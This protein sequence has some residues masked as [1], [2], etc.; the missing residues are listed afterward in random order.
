MNLPDRLEKKDYQEKID[1]LIELTE[2]LKESLIDSK[3]LLEELDGSIDQGVREVMKKISPWQGRNFNEWNGKEAEL[4]KIIVL[5]RSLKYILKRRTKISEE[6]L[7][8]LK[9]DKLKNR[10]K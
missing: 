6:D 9:E 4:K 8:K 7:K 2:D 3:I 1:L 10:L 5:S